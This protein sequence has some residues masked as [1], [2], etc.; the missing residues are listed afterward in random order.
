M[1]QQR[2]KYLHHKQAR[3]DLILIKTLKKSLLRV[4]IKKKMREIVYEKVCQ[5]LKFFIKLA[6]LQTYNVEAWFKHVGKVNTKMI[7]Q[8]WKSLADN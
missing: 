1:K 2:K 8:Y 6:Y 3:K 7:Q 4:F 5:N